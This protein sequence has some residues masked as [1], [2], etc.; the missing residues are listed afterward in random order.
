VTLPYTEDFAHHRTDEVGSWMPG[1]LPPIHTRVLHW[2]RHDRLMVIGWACL[3]AVMLAALLGLPPLL[4]TI[5][6]AT[7]Q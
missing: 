1:P 5:G 6:A 4:R 3:V 7:A 2:L